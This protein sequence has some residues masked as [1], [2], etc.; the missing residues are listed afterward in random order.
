MVRLFFLLR[1]RVMVENLWL[2]GRFFC[3]LL[4]R[5]TRCRNVHLCVDKAYFYER[6]A[7]TSKYG[8]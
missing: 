2:S 4:L 5:L 6:A 8:S 1:K 7:N 3:L